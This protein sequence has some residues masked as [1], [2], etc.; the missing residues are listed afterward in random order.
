MI[1]RAFYDINGNGVFD[2][3]EKPAVGIKISVGS[4]VATSESD[5]TF[6]ISPIAPGTY[7]LKAQPK[8]VSGFHP[9]MGDDKVIVPE[10]GTVEVLIPYEK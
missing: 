4:I 7:Y 5:G 6:A 8:T 1:G 10:A 9:G 2:D 3:G